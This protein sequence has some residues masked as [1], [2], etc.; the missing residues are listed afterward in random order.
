[1]CN[2]DTKLTRDEIIQKI[3]EKIDEFNNNREKQKL[4]AFKFLIQSSK[5]KSS[6]KIR[7]I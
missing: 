1:M 2:I 4:K 6:T 3:N 7:T 5:S